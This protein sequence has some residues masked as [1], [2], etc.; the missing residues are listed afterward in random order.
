[1]SP[2]LLHS[3]TTTPLSPQS[4]GSSSSDSLTIDNGCCSFSPAS[5][6]VSLCILV[7]ASPPPLRPL[8]LVSDLGHGKIPHIRWP[9]KTCIIRGLGCNTISNGTR[10]ATGDG[11]VDVHTLS[12]DQPPSISM[13]PQH[14]ILLGRYVKDVLGISAV[15]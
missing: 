15:D 2:Q 13:S 12:H 14:T 8:A 3:Q 7:R 5:G 4:V 6:L 11:G 1:M 9:S 10:A